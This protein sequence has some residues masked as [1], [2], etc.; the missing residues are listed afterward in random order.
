MIPA[1]P[2][3]DWLAKRL[4]RELISIPLPP[5]ERWARRDR[6]R[7]SRS[8]GM[9]IAIALSVITGLIAGLGVGLVRESAAGTRPGDAARAEG[10]A[11]GLI[12]PADWRTYT[13]HGLLIA[14]PSDWSAPDFL[15]SGEAPGPTAWIVFRGAD[16]SVVFTVTLWNEPLDTV[17]AERWIRGNPQPFTRSDVVGTRRSVELV[18]RGIEWRDPTTATGGTYEA[19]HLLVVLGPN[20]TAAL[21]VTAR[22]I[23]NEAASVSELQRLTQDIVAASLFALPDT[24]RLYERSDVE[25]LLAT[26]GG[27]LQA[28]QFTEARPKAQGL[29]YD[30]NGGNATIDLLVYVDARARASD[31]AALRRSLG[32]DTTARG[33][34]N[35]LL[36]VR[37]ADP[38]VRYRVIASLD[39]LPR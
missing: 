36:R 3:Q 29:A 17:V 34:G 19:R 11:G 18:I 15:K 16:R 4:E 24:T 14:V 7:P 2:N 37:S 31:E 5:P 21:T 26:L 27:Q 28:A 32:P 38:N 12:L 25:R 9:T 6:E 8:V 22:W 20:V 35:L 33:L 30:W 1:D 39:R 10:R 23:P 13:D